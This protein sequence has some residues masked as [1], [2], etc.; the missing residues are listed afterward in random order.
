MDAGLDA[1]RMRLFDRRAASRNG[2]RLRKAARRRWIS[3]RSGLVDSNPPAPTKKQSTLIPTHSSSPFK[4]YSKQVYSK[5][6]PRE[7][8]GDAIHGSHLW[9]SSNILGVFSTLPAVRSAEGRSLMQ[10]EYKIMLD[11]PDCT[12]RRHLCGPSNPSSVSSINS[13]ALPGLMGLTSGQPRAWGRRIGWRSERGGR[14]RIRLDKGSGVI[15]RDYTAWIDSH[16]STQSS[17]GC[18]LSTGLPS[19][20]PVTRSTHSSK[21][22][23]EGAHVFDSLHSVPVS[24]QSCSQAPARRKSDLS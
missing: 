17:F 2:I 7:E 24:I 6:K 12:I 3:G 5:Q 4:V 16:S 1:E 9:K 19:S 18:F 22:C 21:W 8:G 13:Q 10:Y 23:L 15:R 14:L 11:Q 20:A